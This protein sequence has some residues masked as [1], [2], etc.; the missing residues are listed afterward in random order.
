[1]DDNF[2]HKDELLRRL[3]ERYEWFDVLLERAAAQDTDAPGVTEEWSVKDVVAHLIAHEQRSIAEIR[4]AKQG[5]TLAI[6]HEENDSF[7]AGAVFAWRVSSFE[8]MR[9]AWQSSFQQVV[10]TVQALTDADFD[11]YGTVVAALGDTIDGALANN[12]YEHYD[13]HGAQ[14]A[15]WLNRLA[16]N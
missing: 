9:K 3:D 4:A 8:Q 12:T 14:I 5:R 7:N 10:R 16:P 13:Y 6:K 2:V 15:A 11:P 1:L